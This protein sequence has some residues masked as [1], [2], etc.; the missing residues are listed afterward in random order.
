MNE[1]QIIIGLEPPTS[2]ERM[3]WADYKWR[4]FGA[5]PGERG[6]E[7]EVQEGRDE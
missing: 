7:G 2:P 3:Q 1:D 6:Q 5:W 4:T